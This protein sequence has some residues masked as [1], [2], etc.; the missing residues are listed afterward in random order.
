L[1]PIHLLFLLTESSAFGLKGFKYVNL[2]TFL[3]SCVTTS[4]VNE[5]TFTNQLLL[6]NSLKKCPRQVLMLQNKLSF[7]LKPLEGHYKNT[8]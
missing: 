1:L 5:I 4:G 6:N 2:A 3:K 7:S 8:V